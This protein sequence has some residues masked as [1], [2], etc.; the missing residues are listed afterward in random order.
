[1]SKILAISWKMTPT[2]IILAIE[3]IAADKVKNFDRE[4]FPPPN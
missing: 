1:M 2:Q 3:N 4:K